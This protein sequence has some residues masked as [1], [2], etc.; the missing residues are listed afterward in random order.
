MKASL[1]RQIGVLGAGL[2]GH[3]IAQVFARQG[4]AVN[5]FDID[6]QML[7]SAPERI[8][9]NFK[10][11]I[12][13]NLADPEEVDQ[14]LAHIDLCQNLEELCRGADLIIEAVSEKLE[15][16]RGVFSRLEENVSPNA[17][18][19]TNTSAISISKIARNAQYPERIL[20]TH[21][22][23]PPHIIPCVEV[24][25]GAETSTQVFD[26]V[27]EL[28]R[29]MGK[30]PVKV[31]RDIPGFL[32]NRMQHAL[33]REAVKLV[34]EGIAEP[35]DVDDVV[36]YGFGIRLAFLGPL[37]TADLAGLD[38]TCLVHQDLFPHLDRSTMPSSLL[39]NKVKKGELGIKTGRG[40]HDWPPEVTHRTLSIRD[41]VLLRL[42]DQVKA[43][44]KMTEPH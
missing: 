29:E 25:K 13:L 37:Q 24:I 26:A 10:P 5:L 43:S 28:L 3:S 7:S 33:W 14:T 9:Q 21:F 32:G 35:Q 34:E 31:L 23:N 18:L 4:Y 8:R 39:E 16:K 2:M 11:Y 44:D 40:F 36:R 15:V 42:I 41:E 19:A 22:W 30:K 17:V 38:L 12:R 20:G 1:F 6:S 27:Y